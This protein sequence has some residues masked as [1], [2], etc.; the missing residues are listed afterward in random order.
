[1]RRPASV[2][3]YIRSFPAPARRLL[4][5]LRAAI[6]RA[7]PL[8]TEKIS[9]G[10]PTFV[11]GGNLVHYAAYPSHVALY[12]ATRAHAALAPRVAKYQTGKGTLRFALDRP[13]PLGLVRDVVACEVSGRPPSPP[14]AKRAS[15]RSRSRPGSR[16]KS[17]TSASLRRIRGGA[18][19][20]QSTE[21][22]NPTNPA[23]RRGHEPKSLY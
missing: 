21:G 13:L 4:R 20:P 7:A 5:Q 3:V 19:R 8:A 16:T 1:M 22:R 2:E 14:T 23:R 6:R 11:Q 10:I 18:A 9:Y 17:S 12:G 15:T